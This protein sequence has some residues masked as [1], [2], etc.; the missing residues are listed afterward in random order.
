MLPRI[1]Q[2][3]EPLNE[4]YVAVLLATPLVAQMLELESDESKL[5]EI[6]QRM[7]G[8]ATQ[9][10]ER[11]ISVIAVVDRMPLFWRVN[12]QAD[13][14][15]FCITPLSS[16]TEAQRNSL[17][18]PRES[19]H[20]DASGAV[21]FG[22]RWPKL[23]PETGRNVPTE[24]RIQV[25]LANTVFH[26][27]RRSTM[28][29]AHWTTNGMEKLG[30]SHW[31]NP[32]HLSFSMAMSVPVERRLQAPVRWLTPSRR[33]ESAAGNIVR[34]IEGENQDVVTASA[35]LE[36]VVPAYLKENRSEDG[37][38]DI[39]ASVKPNAGV[40]TPHAREQLQLRDHVH[41]V[42]SGGGGWGIK[43]GL[44]S[45]DPETTF[46][47][48]ESQDNAI[49]NDVPFREFF[50]TG[51]AVRFFTDDRK[52]AEATAEQ[53]KR[54]FKDGLL[55]NTKAVLF[56]TSSRLPLLSDSHL[57]LELSRT[58]QDTG[59][60]KPE[61][62]TNNGWAEMN[63]MFGAVSDAGVVLERYVLTDDNGKQILT[64]DQWK[65]DCSKFDIPGFQIGMAF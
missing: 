13:G 16:L 28:Y 53:D 55:P 3:P 50:A 32:S 12:T 15:S 34:K 56:G 27:G 14:I 6:M 10:P 36:K 22:F 19:T 8:N 65:T 31:S 17:E 54:R 52:P 46:M 9:L 57:A 7:F 43:A 49:I 42:L 38:L 47:E 41:K 60:D 25:P 20:I 24:S 23:D 11:I 5:A 2:V 59:S 4:P 35:E 63:N 44:L 39:W 64:S 58:D 40:F 61:L 26:T 21:S 30:L 29:L 33:I 37:R 51:D 62:A 18:T 1:P 48:E 45:L